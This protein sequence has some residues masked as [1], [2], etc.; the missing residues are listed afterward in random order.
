MYYDSLRKAYIDK[1]SGEVVFQEEE[2]AIQPTV[3]QPPTP[4]RNEHMALR[5]DDDSD[6]ARNFER[7]FELARQE[8]QQNNYNQLESQIIEMHR[9]G[10]DPETAAS[11]I[12]APQEHEPGFNDWSL[13][14][15]LQALEFEIPRDGYAE[16][17]GQKEYRASRSCRRQLMTVSFFICL[18]QVRVRSG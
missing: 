13:A 2:E 18:V 5:Q 10:D 1:E 15:T 3:V 7:L 9:L 16:D 11:T 17:F 6:R 14:R 4:L 12:A 8:V